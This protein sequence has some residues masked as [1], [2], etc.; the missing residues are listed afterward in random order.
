MCP[1]WSKPLVVHMSAFV[2]LAHAHCSR[3]RGDMSTT[4]G[5]TQEA[6][7]LGHQAVDCFKRC[8]SAVIIGTKRT[9]YV[10]RDCGVLV[11]FFGKLIRT[12]HFRTTFL[13]RRPLSRCAILAFA[14]RPLCMLLS[15]H[16][17]LPSDSGPALV[18]FELLMSNTSC[19]QLVLV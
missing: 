7:R 11:E 1:R 17:S 16:C 12:L 14:K 19:L 15:F 6:V 8:Y 9:W 5:D 10:K 18:K 4:K 13:T 3:A 2:V